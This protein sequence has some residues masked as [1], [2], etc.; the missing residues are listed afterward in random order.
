MFIPARE[1][2]LRFAFGALLAVGVMSCTGSTLV[3]QH[4]PVP[5]TD[6]RYRAGDRILL[7]VQTAKLE[8]VKT[9]TDTF[10]VV[11]GPAITLP[12]GVGRVSLA[13]VTYPELEQ[14]LTR[15]IG[16]YF[17]NPVVHARTLVRLEVR[18]A[19]GHPGFHA[20]PTDALIDAVLMR[21][22]G[23]TESAQMTDL[24]IQRG[25][26]TLWNGDSIRVAIAS[27]RTIGQLGLESGDVIVV[28][29]GTDL[30]RTMRILGLVLT[31]PATIVGLKLLFR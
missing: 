31:I 13:G 19:V 27:G 28:P 17:V 15:A 5:R 25:D 8:P 30:E 18:G 23:P 11:D 29:K 14:H 4:A 6:I 3:A 20:V 26:T 16:E 24:R 21:A 22:G 2:L 9:L 10:T 12:E 1:N 7:E